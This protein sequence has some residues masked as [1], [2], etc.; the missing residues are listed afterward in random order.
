MTVDIKLVQEQLE[1]VRE[2]VICTRRRFHENPSASG[3]EE[4]AALFVEAQA[5]ELGLAHRRYADYGVLV[6]LEGARP[7]P[8]V[9]LRADYDA[10][11]MQESPDNLAGKK[12]CVSK[13]DGL[14]HACGHD[15]HAA[16]A[17]GAMRVLHALRQQLA[18]SVLF[19]FESGEERGGLTKDAIRAALREE[20]VDTC[21]AIH[22]DAAMP[23]GSCNV[24]PGARLMGA[25]S[26]GATLRGRGGHGSRPDEAVNPI[27]AVAQVVCALQGVI[28]NCVVPG[29]RA[30]LSVGVIEG[31]T[32][33]NIIPETA[34]FAGSVRFLSKETG[35]L[36]LDRVSALVRG[37]AAAEGCEVE[38]LTAKVDLTVTVN[39]EKA[40]A[41]AREGIEKLLGQEVLVSREPWMGSESFGFCLEQ[42]SGAMMFLG[43]ANA[44]KGTGAAHHNPRFDLDE[45]AL[46]VGVAAEV[47]YVLASM[48]LL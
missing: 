36:I 15:G 40:C 37:I 44:Q 31:G 35:Q 48:K 11:S 41:T 2:Y 32:V 7:G 33:R 17:L 13:E 39:D 43:I 10:L 9:C 47:G 25:A 27:N 22:L 6:R 3:K 1:T 46:Q 19:L 29:E 12:V 21:F 34:S 8:T 5:Q 42:A 38:S 45:D 18:G 28:P 24:E 16:M 20:K 23:T 4:Q 26:I 14:C 30:V